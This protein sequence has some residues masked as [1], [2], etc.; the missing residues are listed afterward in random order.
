M[1]SKA[2]DGSG[3]LLVGGTNDNPAGANVAGHALGAS[4]Y[5]STTRDG[6]FAAFL[7]RKT[8]DGEIVRLG[9][10]GS[11]VGSIGTVSSNLFI[12]TGDTGVYFNASEDKI[13]PINTTT[14]AGRDAAIDLGK[15][16]TR[17]KDLYLSGFISGGST[18]GLT[19]R[20]ITSGGVAGVQL[21]QARGSIG[22]PTTSLAGGD[23]SYITSSVY[24]GSAFNKIAQIGL[25]TGTSLDD[26]D[27]VFATAKAGTTTTR[28]TLN[29]DGR[30]LFGRSNLITF[31]SNTTDGIVL[32]PNRL[33]VSAASL[34]RITQVRDSTGTLDRFYNG[35]S[36]VGSIT[37][38]TSA[39][40][41]NTSSDQRLKS[42]IVDAPSASDDIDAIQVRSFDWKV[43]GSHQKYGMVAQEL[44]TVAPNAVSQPEDPEEMMGVDYSK[45]V[46]MLIKE[47][48]QL[49]ARV[50]Q[51]EGEN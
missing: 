44:V 32:Y 42:N 3:N 26:G 41:F 33:D 51:L 37:C 5:I 21:Q 17:F 24:D 36:I 27:I 31:G 25:V 7:N 13:Y 28:M 23:G 12:G 2:I 50:A 49:R 22:T 4:G 6:G 40:A 16:D 46:P 9:K 29:E 14:N 18:V 20:A 1:E 34:A 47:V 35:T 8:S 48:Q 38:T 15:S 39:T 43:D 19:T 11:T 30:L 45:L 10:D